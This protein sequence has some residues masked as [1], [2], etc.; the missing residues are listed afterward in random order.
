MSHTTFPRPTAL[1][2]T[3]Q[4]ARRRPAPKAGL[5]AST[6]ATCD[7]S[8][9]D[10][11]LLEEAAQQVGPDLF[12][13]HEAFRA[14]ARSAWGALSKQTRDWVGEFRAGVSARPE[15]Y[16]R[17]LPRDTSLPPTPTS[18]TGARSTSSYLSELLMTVF[19]S[20]LG[21]PISYADQRNGA[22]FHDIY[23]T[24]FNAEKVS[25][26]SSAVGLGFHSEMFFHPSPPD[27]LVLHCLRQDPDGTALTGVADLADIERSLSAKDSHTLREPEF[28]LDLARLHGSYHYANQRIAKED[29]RPCIPVITEGEEPRFRF[30][31]AL[32]SPTSD[33]GRTALLHAERAA[34]QTA[35]FGALRAG[36]MLLLD[37]RRSAHSRTSFTARFDGTDRW[38]RRTMV[39]STGAS[40]EQGVVRSNNLDLWTP[41]Q[42]LG[43]RFEVVPYAPNHRKAM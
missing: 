8:T 26:Q 32:M 2:P 3:R 38:L 28:A 27:F 36:G 12:E 11:E 33:R 20:Q 9:A 31:P 25:S 37:N 10:H 16:I 24:T 21:F 19:V 41:W 18:D 1:P 6:W 30:E 34:E 13:D 14:H 22:I 23:P 17:N 7:V 40:Q 43:A 29:P 5:P 35:T 39:A 42:S 15:L 4:G